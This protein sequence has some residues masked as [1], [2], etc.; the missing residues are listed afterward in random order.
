MNRIDFLFPQYRHSRKSSALIA[1]LGVVAFLSLIVVALTIGMKLETQEAHYYEART[2]SDLLA[3]NGVEAVKASLMTACASGNAWASAPGM[4]VYASPGK[5]ASVIPLFSTAGTNGTGV[6]AP[7]D[8]NRVAVTDDGQQVITGPLNNGN[9]SMNIGWIYVFQD[10]TVSTNQTPTLTAANPVI[11]RYAYWADDESGRINVNTA[12]GSAGNTN[13]PNHPSW[14]GLGNLF[15]SSLATMVATN[16][17]NS[18]FVSVDM[19]RLLSTNGASAANLPGLVSSNRFSLSASSF[20]P[21]LNPFGQQKILLTT[22]ARLTNGTGNTNFLNILATPNAD[23]GSM[24]SLSTNGLASTVSNLTAILSTN[25]PYFNTSFAAKYTPYNTNRVTQIA[26]DIIEYV[27]AAESTNAGV[28][29]IRGAWNAS[30]KFDITQTSVTN[31]FIG[32][33]RHPVI[34]QM[35]IWMTNS[36]TFSALYPFGYRYAQAEIGLYLPPNYGIASYSLNNCTL[37][38]QTLLSFPSQLTTTNANWANV[39]IP[40]ANVTLS[41]ANPLTP[42]SYCLIT[43]GFAY[44]SATNANPGVTYPLRVTLYDPTS[45]VNPLETAP[46]IYGESVNVPVTVSGTAPTFGNSIPMAE[47]SDP[48]V[49]KNP[50]AWTSVTDNLGKPSLSLTAT[51]TSPPQDTDASGNVS[52]ASLVMPKVKGTSGAK[53]YVGSVAELGYITTG[54]EA[55]T[56]SYHSVPWRTIRLQPTPAKSAV[57][58]PDW[59]LL[60]FFMAPISTNSPTLYFPQTNTVAG[61]INLNSG[62]PFTNNSNIIRQSPLLALFQAANSPLTNNPSLFAT[63]IPSMV[64]AAG[65]TNYGIPSYLSPGEIA[66]VQGVSDGGESTETN[67]QDVVD[68]G[69]AQGDIFRVYSIGQALK[70]TSGNPPTLIVLSEQYKEA[71]IYGYSPIHEGNGTLFWKGVSP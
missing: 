7:P 24:A 17:T 63:N 38:L 6:Y 2:S 50:N 61:R 29:P 68:L 56:N 49:N 43:A 1:V 25:L 55:A 9:L 16:A 10:G 60:D 53:G 42:G 40:S 37:T 58:P 44:F 32:T 62:A 34:T 41:G 23:P 15:G 51:N 5:K 30:G 22:Q 65:G 39:V 69:T 64:L 19:I 67:L 59:A 12:W 14:I 13:T 31:T 8:L 46:A 36:L 52:S 57:L 33:S 27:R 70:Q 20:S 54:A 3:W 4:V 47:V 66:E 18:P 28:E 21:N 11:G 45:V 48:R 26:L 71:I 35:A